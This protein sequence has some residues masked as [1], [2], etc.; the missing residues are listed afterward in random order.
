MTL[1]IAVG[2][3]LFYASGI[4]GVAIVSLIAEATVL[5]VLAAEE[6]GM[7][8]GRLR[9]FVPGAALGV[10]ALGTVSCCATRRPGR[11]PPRR[12]DGRCSVWR[13]RRGSFEIC[14]MQ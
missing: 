13:P 3:P 1:N 11:V 12:W 8:F 9:W 5:V 6:P 7:F 10:V 2:V 14:A 4:R